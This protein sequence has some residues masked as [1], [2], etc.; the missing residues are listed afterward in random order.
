MQPEILVVACLARTRRLT[1]QSRD[2][3]HQK[4]EAIAGRFGLAEPF[5]AE[6]V[7][8]EPVSQ[9]VIRTLLAEV[10]FL[11]PQVLALPGSRIELE[12]DR[13]TSCVRETEHVKDFPG[14]S[15]IL[16]PHL[17]A[18]LDP[19][20]KPPYRTAEGMLQVAFG[21]KH[22]TILGQLAHHGLQR[23]SSCNQHISGP[24]SVTGRRA[25]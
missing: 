17:H 9:Q 15:D 6:D 7:V 25:L 11:A 3:G 19:W 18:N 10:E 13:S 20:I 21:M 2:I 8:Y 23:N 4:R 16:L 14:V 24:Y 22:L 1:P 5:K 12:L